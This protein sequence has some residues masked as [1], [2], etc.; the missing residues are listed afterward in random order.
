MT[1][2]VLHLFER[3]FHGFLR[4]FNKG[5]DGVLGKDSSSSRLSTLP[6]ATWAEY[7]DLA[8]GGPTTHYSRLPSMQGARVKTLIAL[9]KH[10]EKCPQRL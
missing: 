8:A 6:S 1:S 9:P 4:E 7:E 5:T 10:E 2:S 3:H